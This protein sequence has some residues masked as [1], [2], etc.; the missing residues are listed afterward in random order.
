MRKENDGTIS[1]SVFRKRTHTDQ[2]RQFSF[3]CPLAHKCS[4]VRTLFFR[5]SSLSSSLVQ[6]SLEEKHIFDAL[7]TNGYPK[8]LIQRR[9]TSQR[10][11]TE[12]TKEK[13]AARVTLP[14]VQGVSE[15]IRW[16]L[17][18]PGYYYI[19]QTHDFSQED[20]ISSERPPFSVFQK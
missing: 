16:D 17:K 7:R 5:A 12:E 6:R 15:A 19:L 13:L 3:H 8:N 18:R 2:Y 10:S 1:T 4:V 9:S 20:F 14:Y 11:E